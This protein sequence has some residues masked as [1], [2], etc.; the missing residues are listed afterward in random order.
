M[1]SVSPPP[2]SLSLSPFLHGKIL[3]EGRRKSTP[4]R[5]DS[6]D[7]VTVWRR[8]DAGRRSSVRP[9]IPQGDFGRSGVTTSGRTC[10]CRCRWRLQVGVLLMFVHRAACGNA[11]SGKVPSHYF[12]I[13]RQRL[14]DDRNNGITPVWSSKSARSPLVLLAVHRRKH[15]KLDA[16]YARYSIKMFAQTQARWISA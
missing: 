14:G 15:L 5:R 8:A 16:K 12:T 2:L 6:V 4:C 10:R 13:S 9:V 3:L 7:R 11:L 1:L